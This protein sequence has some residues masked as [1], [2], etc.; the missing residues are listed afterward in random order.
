LQDSYAAHFADHVLRREIVATGAVNYV[1]N[2]GGIAL[3][4]R[5]MANAQANIG[6]AIAAYLDVDRESGAA[7]L[8]NQILAAG[9]AAKEEHEALLEIENA[10]EASAKEL[11]QGNKTSK[12]KKILAD[13]R[14]RLKL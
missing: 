1:I 2:N 14:Q 11:L 4:P 3:L 6:D 13:L 7:E 9:F 5:L 8:R 12:A 10:V